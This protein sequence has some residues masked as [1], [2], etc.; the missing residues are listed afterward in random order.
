MGFRADFCV[1]T[2][3]MEFCFST[4]TGVPEGSEETACAK[5]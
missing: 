1:G 3:Q 4:L 5:P 2:E